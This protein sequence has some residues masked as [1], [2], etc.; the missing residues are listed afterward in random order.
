M[1]EC[2]V[3]LQKMIVKDNEQSHAII[4][5]C[6]RTLD[7]INSGRAKATMIYLLKEFIDRFPSLAKETFR[8]LVCGFIQESDS[9][10]KLQIINLGCK[11]LI[12]N[13]EDQNVRE[14]FDYLL[15]LA[16]Y[17]KSYIIRQKA[18]IL[19][20]IFNPDHKID[21]TLLFKEEEIKVEEEQ[22]VEA[23]A[24]LDLGNCLGLLGTF[25]T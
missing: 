25:N 9:Q 4:L 24:N 15:K 11:V 16:N 21:A 17:D 10:V 14:I 5:Y 3:A 7:K 12:K 19:S 2:I 22:K 8:R 18:R 1:T 6:V 13:T 20:Y 23:A